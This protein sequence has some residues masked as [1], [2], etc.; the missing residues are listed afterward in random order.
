MRKKWTWICCKCKKEFDGEVLPKV[1]NIT[2]GFDVCE[3]C[4]EAKE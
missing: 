3:E 2:P 1:S 4:D